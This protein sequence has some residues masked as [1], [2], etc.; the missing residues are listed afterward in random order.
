MDINYKQNDVKRID[1]QRKADVLLERD[2]SK[3]ETE[4]NS[5]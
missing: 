3:V 2:R 1:Q 5:S 4:R